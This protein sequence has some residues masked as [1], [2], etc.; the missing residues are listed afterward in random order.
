MKKSELPIEEIIKKYK[1]GISKIAKEY[2]VSISTISET[3]MEF[4]QK[5]NR[6]GPEKI[7]LPVEEIIKK[8]ELGTSQKEL[9]QE[10]GVS[11]LTIAKRI[12]AYYKDTG[13]AAPLLDYTRI[14]LPIEDIIKKYKLGISQEQLAKEY[15]VSKT[16]IG[17]KIKK[18]YKENGEE[19]IEKDFPRIKLPVEEIVKK[20]EDG[21]SPLNISKEYNVARTTILNRLNEYYQ[22]EGRE[23]PKVKYKNHN[24]KE[25]KQIN[26]NTR[27]KQL[28]IE[29]IITEYENGE[30]QAYLAKKYGVSQGTILIRIKEYYE[31]IGKE[32]P[33]RRRARVK[34]PIEDIIEKYKSEISQ[35]ELAQEYGVSSTT[36]R[37]KMKKYYEENGEEKPKKDLT[38]IKLPIED[39]IK[40]YESGINELTLAEEYNVAHSTISKRMAKFYNENG[41]KTPRILRNI[42]IIVDYLER[43]LTIE[44]IIEIAL[45]KNIIIPQDIIDD[46]L[47]KVNGKNIIDDNEER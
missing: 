22:K 43:G 31:D 11:R 32:R 23:K 19:K 9:A 14:R 29:Q 2:N 34:L 39:I 33:K 4:L 45:N 41:R 8:H 12:K 40:K 18:Y 24:D 10:Y 46:A 38:K 17:N 37:N 7:K 13:K 47:N 36:I 44:K 26:S 5:Q 30:K 15:G 1:E 6:K 20:Y 35:R 27:R 25:R 42:S 21:T 28:P 16:T 3:I